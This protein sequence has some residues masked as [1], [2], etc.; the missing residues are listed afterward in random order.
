MNY[1]QKCPVCE[2]SGKYNDNT[3]HGCEGKGWVTV[4]NDRQKPPIPQW[5][6]YWGPW[7]TY[8]TATISD[9]SD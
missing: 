9:K 5:P 1:A 7:I 6:D 3:C 2:G 8:C 4:Q